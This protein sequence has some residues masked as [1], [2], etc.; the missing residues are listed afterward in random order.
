VYPLSVTPDVGN[1]QIEEQTGV[2]TFDSKDTIFSN[3][4]N[5]DIAGAVAKLKAVLVSQGYTEQ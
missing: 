5:D 1:I 2:L 4:A 3:A